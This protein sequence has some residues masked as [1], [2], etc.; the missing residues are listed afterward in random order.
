MTGINAHAHAG[1][2]FHAV[3]DRRQMFELKTEIAA[4][5]GG[6]FDHRGHAV[7]FLQGDVDGLSNTRQTGVF[8]DLHQMATRME[9]QQRQPQLFTAL[10]FIKERLAGFIQRFLNRM[11]EVNQI[12]VVGKDLAR[13]V[14]V[15][16]T[17]GFEIINHV[18][19]ERCGAPLALIF[20]EQG[21]SGCLDFGGANGGVC[22]AT[23]S[24]DVR[25]NIFHKD[26]C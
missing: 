8:V 5:T 16:F 7:G 24:A 2:I 25:S 12:A 22:K 19:G 20:G 9:V 13:P 18:G 23:C 4:L 15:F 3:D 26:S 14:V 17:G 6:V 10:H 21:E 11:T 1:F